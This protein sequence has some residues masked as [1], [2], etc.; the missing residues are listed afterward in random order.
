[1]ERAFPVVSDEGEYSEI[2]D[3]DLVGLMVQ[4]QV[5]A[6]KEVLS[7]DDE[8]FDEK[9]KEHRAKQRNSMRLAPRAR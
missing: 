8:I 5:Q 3:Q 1:M 2:S 7:S 9:R 6:E 4:A